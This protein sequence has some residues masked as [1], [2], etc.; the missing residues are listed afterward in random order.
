MLARLAVPRRFGFCSR[1]DRP[2]SGQ[3]ALR[4]KAVCNSCS[5]HDRAVFV[6]LRSLCSVARLVGIGLFPPWLASSLGGDVGTV[7]LSSGERKLPVTQGLES[8]LKASKV[9]SAESV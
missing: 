1:N 4:E 7:V 3:R 2:L 9:F 6:G 5:R 8:V